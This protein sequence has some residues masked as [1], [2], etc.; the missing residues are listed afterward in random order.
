MNQTGQNDTLNLRIANF[1]NMEL[2]L[3][4]VLKFDSNNIDQI[5]KEIRKYADLPYVYLL[6]Q[7]KRQLVLELLSA[8]KSIKSPCYPY[9]LFFVEDIDLATDHLELD[10]IKSP[11]KNE[12]AVGDAIKEYAASRLGIDYEKLKFSNAAPLP[13][14]ID[15]VII[16][17]GI[18]GIYA[19]NELIAKGISVC[20]VDKLDMVG[21]IWSIYANAT[22]QVNTSEGAYRL[23]DSK[24][25]S[26]RDHSAT[27]EILEDIVLLSSNVREHLYLNTEVKRF[28]KSNNLY[29]ILVERYGQESTIESKG[30]ILAINDRVGTPRQIEWPGQSE[31]QG[32]IV[33]GISN[34]AKNLD[35]RNKRVV[36]VGMGA[37]A[38]ENARTALE[39]GASSVTVVCRRH[40]TVCPKIIDYL[41]FSSPYD[42]N[43]KH[44]KKSNMR[45]MIYWKKLYDLSGATQPECWMG[46]IKHEGHT[47]SVSDIWF[48]AH[49]LKKLKTVTG[50]ITSIY[51]NGVTVDH[52][53]RIEADIV[54]NCVGFHRN[55]PVVKTLCDYKEMYNN[56]YVDKDLMYLADAYL[57]NDDVFNSFFGS[58]VLE[59]AKFYMKVF[60][61][62]F[63]NPAFEDMLESEGIQKISIED[64]RWSHYIAGATALIKRYPDIH[65]ATLN[66]IDQRTHNFLE[67]HDIETFVAENKREWIDMHSHLAGKEMSEEECLPY[68]FEKLLNS[69]F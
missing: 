25:R 50:S 14:K 13:K 59:M 53:H 8:L 6:S 27:R 24:T 47:I 9:A 34:K 51:K 45:N 48:I 60:I 41:N 46:K 31:F 1:S 2:P 61:K 20:I 22:S 16:G 58:S 23:I 5:V 18:T 52:Q 64:R 30:I 62:F 35:W 15:V 10:I 69:K 43:F 55:A 21:G 28:G 11:G 36:V 19:A 37:F 12:I 54:V 39:G 4:N 3:K 38:T 33:P 67:V 26:N 57:D 44:D 66:Q 56:N 40:G 63:D 42:E 49:Y 17:A 68:V 65:Q 29:K 32:D 7:E